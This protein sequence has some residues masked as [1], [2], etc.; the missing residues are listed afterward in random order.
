METLACDRSLALAG[1]SPACAAAAL[2]RADAAVV[3]SPPQLELEYL[4]RPELDA[5]ARAEFR[6]WLA[7]FERRFARLLA[8]GFELQNLAGAG[9]RL[10]SAA[11]GEVAEEFQ[12][13]A[14]REAASAKQ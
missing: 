9:Y 1:V 12:Q 2:A 14:A 13:L 6:V 3:C 11:A 7:G 10:A 5:S 8:A 4:L